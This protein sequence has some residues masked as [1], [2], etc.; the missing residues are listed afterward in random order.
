MLKFTHQLENEHYQIDT[1]VAQVEC[2]WFSSR[3][4][5]H[6]LLGQSGKKLIRFSSNFLHLV[7]V[8]AV[9]ENRREIELKINISVKMVRR[10]CGDHRAASMCVCVWNVWRGRWVLNVKVL[11]LKCWQMTHFSDNGIVCSHVSQFYF[12]SNIDTKRNAYMDFPCE[13]L[14]RLKHN[15]LRLSLP[16]ARL[17]QPFAECTLCTH[18]FN[19]LVFF[20]FSSFHTFRSHTG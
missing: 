3:E 18:L 13:R 12:G 11:R 10:R 19:V 17:A 15:Y 20:F 2:D 1:K 9:S 5:P 7:D 4:K 14:H 6:W 16:P 8:E